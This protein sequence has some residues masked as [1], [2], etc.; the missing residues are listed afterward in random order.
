MLCGCYLEIHNKFPQQR[1]GHQ[2]VIVETK[3]RRED[4]LE[5]RPGPSSRRGEDKSWVKLLEKLRPKETPSIFIYLYLLLNQGDILGFVPLRWFYIFFTV[6]EV[7][8]FFATKQIHIRYRCFLGSMHANA[9]VLRRRIRKKI[10]ICTKDRAHD[11]VF[12]SFRLGPAPVYVNY[13]AHYAFK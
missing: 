8:L 3:C 11:L 4:R 7:V 1:A 13:T 10:A 6:F 12:A 9:L 2:L 5:Q